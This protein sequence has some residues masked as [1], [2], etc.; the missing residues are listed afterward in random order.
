MSE[1][2]G[3]SIPD[4]DLYT[5]DLAGNSIFKRHCLKRLHILNVDRNNGTGKIL[6]ATGPPYGTTTTSRAFSH[7]VQRDSQFLSPFV[8]RT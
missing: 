3:L 7:Q 6:S 5:G 8:T 1:D 4:I 2:L